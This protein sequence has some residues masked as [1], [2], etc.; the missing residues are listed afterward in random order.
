MVFRTI[1][2]GRQY[3]RVQDEAVRLK[4]FSQTA[5]ATL[6][7]G[8]VDGN[9][10]IHIMTTI[11]AGIVVLD[12]VAA[13]AGIVEFAKDQENDPTYDVAVEFTAMRAAAV[14]VRDWIITNFPKDAGGFI[15]KDTLE[16]SGAVTVRQFSPTDT[17]PLRTELQTLID[18]IE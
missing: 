9:L 15:L 18:A 1:G 16:L 7:R 13:M 2:L 11:V 4:T 12:D 3:D 8:P 14:S 10:I 6:Q 17:F 5:K